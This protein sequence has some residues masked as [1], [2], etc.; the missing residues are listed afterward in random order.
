MLMRWKLQKEWRVVQLFGLGAFSDQVPKTHFLDPINNIKTNNS[1]NLKA[2]TGRTY[3]LK[4]IGKN[5]TYF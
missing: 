2:H 4:Q 5:H 3:C 1:Q